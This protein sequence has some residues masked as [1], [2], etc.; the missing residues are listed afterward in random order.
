MLATIKAK[1]FSLLKPV[2]K[3]MQRLGAREKVI[4]A[5]HVNQILSMVKPGDI[6]LSYEA[7]RFTSVFIPGKWDHASI[8][9]ERLDVMEAVG[10]FYIKGE[11]KGGVRRV[12]LIEWL[13]KKDHVSLI[14]PLFEDPLINFK[15]GENANR[16]EGEGYDYSFSL[17][18]ETIYCSELVYL[19]YQPLD[20]CFMNHITKEILPQDYLKACFFKE[21]KFVLLYS[22]RV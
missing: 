13:Y 22:T 6:L 2:Q 15:A 7:Q 5:F 11:N 19:C 14:R 9:T 1:L 12:Q 16:Y 20:S 17:N 10:D 8:V 4:T 18:N 21:A 3:L